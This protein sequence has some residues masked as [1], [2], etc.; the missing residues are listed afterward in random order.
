ML[1]V[2]PTTTENSSL[3]AICC[4]SAGSRSHFHLWKVKCQLVP[5]TKNGKT[6]STN[7]FI[8]KTLLKL[9][10]PQ[11]PPG[12]EW[13][14]AVGSFV[15]TAATLYYIPSDSCTVEGNAG[16]GTE[17][18]SRSTPECPILASWVQGCMALARSPSL[19]PAHIRVSSSQVFSGGRRLITG[20]ISSAQGDPQG[21]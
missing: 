5:N 9:H 8:G 12:W 14:C 15:N 20:G 6:S 19:L 16:A 18:E 11:L 7:C 1:Q 13:G 10:K 3:L 2:T 17:R 4:H 21:L